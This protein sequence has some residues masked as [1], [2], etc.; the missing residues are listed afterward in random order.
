MTRRTNNRGVVITAIS[1]LMALLLAA[2]SPIVPAPGGTVPQPST[3]APTEES[4]APVSATGIYKAFAPGAS[5]P[6]LDMTLYLN[7]DGTLRLVNDY[8]NEEPPYVEV[9][10]WSEV[11][12][13]VTITITGPADPAYPQ[14]AEPAAR[15]LTLAGSQLTSADWIGPWYEFGALATGEVTPA[16][17]ASALTDVAAENDF[18][19]FYKAF[20][21]SASCCGLDQTLL[22]AFDNSARLTSDYLNGEA[23]IVE[24][25]SWEADDEG[26]ITVTLTGRDDG[27]VYDTPNVLVLAVE[28]GMLV[29]VEAD[30]SRYGAG[31]VF[32]YFPGLA[33]PMMR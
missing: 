32:Y 24:T 18:A 1:L 12:S 3:P 4:A 7:A 15:T 31:L 17:E 14:P 28:E 20:S 10:E 9:G 25:G 2:C 6:G 16:Y 33:L 8:Q 5:S 26:R 21:P 23:P 27:T 22:L 29:T 13:S 19:G 30:A 11:D